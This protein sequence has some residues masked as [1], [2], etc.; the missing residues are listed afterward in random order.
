MGRYEVVG[1]AWLDLDYRW[2]QACHAVAPGRDLD[3]P[4]SFGA[5]APTLTTLSLE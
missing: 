5:L 1:D 2:F 3:G 4:V